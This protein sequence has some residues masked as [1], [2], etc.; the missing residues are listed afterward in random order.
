[1]RSS[2][3]NIPGTF[4]PKAHKAIVGLV[5]YIRDEAKRRN[6]PKIYFFPIDEPGDKP[7]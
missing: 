3:R 1:M 2:L 5:Q 7:S 6:W 4:S